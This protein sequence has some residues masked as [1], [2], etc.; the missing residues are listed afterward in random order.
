MSVAMTLS[1]GMERLIRRRQRDAMRLRRGLETEHRRAVSNVRFFLRDKGRRLA[2]LSKADAARRIIQRNL[3]FTQGVIAS[4]L[5]ITPQGRRVDVARWFRGGG[6]NVPL[7]KLKRIPAPPTATG[8]KWHGNPATMFV[9]PRRGRRRHQPA[10]S[11][12]YRARGGAG[13]EYDA[14][15][16]GKGVKT[17]VK[18]DVDYGEVIDNNRRAAARIFLA[19]MRDR[20]SW[21]NVAKNRRF[22]GGQAG[23][24]DRSPR[25][26]R[27]VS[28]VP[29]FDS[30]G[31]APKNVGSGKGGMAP[32]G[33]EI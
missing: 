5:T 26:M 12:F 13:A 24:I 32:W 16:R 21:K 20:F 1:G 14:A 23:E 11:V 6:A 31:S 7:G 8:A 27:G 28:W 3:G 33:G 9:L 25:Q 29:E 2:G 18:M 17:R 4:T 19:Y 30:P 10:V 22:R 15:T